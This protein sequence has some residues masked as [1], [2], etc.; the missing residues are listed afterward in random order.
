MPQTP[1]ERTNLGA[2]SKNGKIT[3]LGL[4]KNFYDEDIFTMLVKE[5]YDY[6]RTD[7]SVSEAAIRASGSLGNETAIKPL[8]QIIE[9]GS[10]SQRMEAIR[11]LRSIR[12]PST[13]NQLIKYF[14][15]FPEEN[16]R[17]EILRAINTIT[18]TAA[19]VQ[20][21]NTA[22]YGD[23]KQS[24]E[25]KQ[26][27]V[28][29]LVEAERYPLLKESLS[30]ASPAVQE[31]AFLKMLQSGSQEVLDFRKESLS[32]AA[33]GCYLCLYAVKAKT[34]D[35]TYILETLQDGH[36]QTLTSF[37]LALSKFEG[38]LRFPTRVFRLLLIVPYSDPETESL[39]GDF[40]KKI[41]SEV[42]EGAPHLVS[43][44]SVV[45]SAQ[46]DTVFA[47]IKKNYVSLQGIGNRDVLLTTILAKLLERH[48]TPTVLAE[49][50]AFFKEESIR[51]PPLASLR[52]LLATAPKEERNQLEACIPIFS[53]TERKERLAVLASLSR[54]D[55]NRPFLLRRLN[56][57]IRV[58]GSLNL[59]SAS[60]KIEEILQFA[61]AERVHYLEETSIV[62]L[63][64]LLTRSVIERARESLR[65]PQRST[66]A[67][68]GYI[69]GARF[70]PA[71]AMAAPLIHVVQQPTLNH[72]SR[73]LTIDSLEA[74][75]L[76]GIQ[77]ALPPLLKVLDL[78][79]VAED[80]KLRIGDLM[81]RACDAEIG[82]PALD[83]TG[84]PTPIGRR[85]AV[86]ILR[87]LAQR[88][89][90]P[91]TEVLTNRLYMLLEDSERSVRVEAILALLAMEDDY[92]VQIVNDYIQAGDVKMITEI[93]AGITRPV[94][95]D[96]FSLLLAMLRLDDP[97]VHS[98][99]GAL[100]P[101]LSQGTFS[102]DLR[103]GLLDIMNSVHPPVPAST[104]A[105][106]VSV[107]APAEQ[108]STLG[109]AKVEFKFRRENTQE[110]TVFFI[111]MAGFTEKSNTI[112]DEMA[113]LIGVI[114]AFE[115]IVSNAVES[116]GGTIVKKMGDG[117]LAFFKRPL[118]A[119][120]AALNVQS[121]IQ[122]YSS[123]RVEQEKFRARIGL[124]TGKVIRKDG[125]IFGE[126]VNVA[127]RMQSRATP[128]E[129]LLT[130]ATYTEIK[131]YVDCTQ[132]GRLEVKGIKDGVTAFVLQKVRVDLARLR[133][134]E[135]VEA[136]PT[137]NLRDP[138]L[139]RLKESY[140][141]PTFAVP[142]GKTVRAASQLQQIFSDISRS[143]EDFSEDPH[144]TFRFKQYLQ[145][146]WNALIASL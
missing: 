27:A 85:V 99:L 5:I 71:K 111:D 94:T 90:G 22:V 58:A 37:L 7:T 70:I 20:Q 117:I 17:T 60:K 46:L 88:R 113:T 40:L 127:S 134:G 13:V 42:K 77:K 129:V 33:L 131:D 12:A 68:N 81:G 132:L 135:P 118:S 103:Q 128:G 4:L 138:S 59:R 50:Q 64:Q 26:I 141:Q 23:P 49:T 79:G 136:G 45:V 56:R 1:A 35:T 72:T 119:A 95:R 57:L 48:G 140:F 97:K 106:L 15:H 47:K 65:D 54:V 122:A 62:T 142:A 75:D 84:H 82:H 114:K 96:T 91:A 53:I 21:L 145:D 30:K 78:Q 116:N 80:L 38:R 63:C 126:V 14:N 115:D 143:I 102:E 130:E 107:A 32:P 51:P 87:G 86:R 3:I 112:R 28:E 6:D 29:A 66:R 10:M 133:S 18:P 2:L 34:P 109:Q 83:L 101:E 9:R 11:A 144:E 98:L 74:M 61:R 31:T 43:E 125:D 8:Y 41:V 73:A 16:L 93:L 55:L 52:S 105:E 104:G 36:R 110:L 92:A 44:F 24:D 108:A 89:Q 69:R 146:Q 25:A 137:G 124:N 19:A 121:A 67:L 76:T 120:V 123:M 39:V 100:L 139:E